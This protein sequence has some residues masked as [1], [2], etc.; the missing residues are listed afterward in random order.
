MATIGYKKEMLELFAKGAFKELDPL[1]T[2]WAAKTGYT[3]TF[4]DWV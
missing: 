2:E 3:G 1:F 4:D